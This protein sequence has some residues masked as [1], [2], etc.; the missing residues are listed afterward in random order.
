MNK[1]SSNLE[2][3]CSDKENM[4]TAEMTEGIKIWLGRRSNRSIFDG[5]GFESTFA[6][7]GEGQLSPLPLW[8]RR[9]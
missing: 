4:R 5:T 9:P 1:K 2:N 8:V 7:M 3:T 6:K